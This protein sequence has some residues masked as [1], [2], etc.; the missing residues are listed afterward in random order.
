MLCTVNAPKMTAQA[1]QT[2]L[3]ESAISASLP[4]SIQQ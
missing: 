3:T 4:S 2:D 1:A